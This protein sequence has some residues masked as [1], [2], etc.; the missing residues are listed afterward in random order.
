M[1]SH[2]PCLICREQEPQTQTPDVISEYGHQDIAIDSQT[3]DIHQST[4]NFYPRLRPFC[5][6][7]TMNQY[8]KKSCHFLVTSIHEWPRCRWVLNAV[9]ILV[10]ITHT[11]ESFVSRFEISSFSHEPQET[12]VVWQSGLLS[13]KRWAF[14]LARMAFPTLSAH[15]NLPC[16]LQCPQWAIS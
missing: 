2:R 16:P 8:F 5:L 14:L 6:R 13:L 3:D 9:S 15:S 7:C 11:V 10:S 1:H 12:R 4:F